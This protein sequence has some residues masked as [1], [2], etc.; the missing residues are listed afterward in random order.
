MKDKFDYLNNRTEGEIAFRIERLLSYSQ[1][2]PQKIFVVFRLLDGHFIDRWT[3][4]RSI[5]SPLSNVSITNSSIT[6]TFKSYVDLGEIFERVNSVGNI[7]AEC[8]STISLDWS[9]GNNTD[10]SI[11]YMNGSF[12]S[13]CG[14]G[15]INFTLESESQNEDYSKV[16]LYSIIVTLLATSQIFN[17]IWL[18]I[19]IA[20]SQT[21]ANGISMLTILQNIV[22][23]A[24]GCLCHF[25][26][27]VNYDVRFILINKY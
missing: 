3:L 21:Y 19:K 22:W 20:N 12:Q 16:M 14:F 4:I 27:T 26:L 8:K 13:N 23:N 2:D 1:V 17:T 18:T 9:K 15:N 6:Q 5:D 25:F 7:S 10:K 11:H 24:Y